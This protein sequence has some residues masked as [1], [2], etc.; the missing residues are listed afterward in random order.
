MNGGTDLEGLTDRIDSCPDAREPRGVALA[1]FVDRDTKLTADPQPGEPDGRDDEFQLQDAV[2]E[3][4]Q[5]RL[6]RLQE[7][8]LARPLF[9]DPARKRRN[10]GAF[11]QDRLLA[12]QFGTGLADRCL[13]QV[14]FDH[15]DGVEFEERLVGLGR[16]LC[17]L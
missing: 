11:V 3:D 7:L 16:F 1:G 5:H 15:A 6:A 4:V 2:V 12:A 14:K 9:G 10:D 8:L 13:R 17:G